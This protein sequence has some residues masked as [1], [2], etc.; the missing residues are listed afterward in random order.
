[1]T[2]VTQ[3]TTI[4]QSFFLFFFVFVRTLRVDLRLRLLMNVSRFCSQ[5]LSRLSSCSLKRASRCRD[6]C[7]NSRLFLDRHWLALRSLEH[8]VVARRYLSCLANHFRHDF[9]HRHHRCE[10]FLILESHL[11]RA[12]R[13]WGKIVLK[14]NKNDSMWCVLVILILII[15]IDVVDNCW[16]WSRHMFVRTR[17]WIVWW[18]LSKNNIK[19]WSKSKVINSFSHSSWLWALI[20]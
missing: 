3:T 2:R 1:M 7:W 4:C 8:S 6:A 9:K 19:R 10:L 15:T 18:T 11:A 17:T 20:D 14:V 13:S 5:S 12:N 16:E